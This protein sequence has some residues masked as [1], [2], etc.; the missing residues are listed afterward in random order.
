MQPLWGEILPSDLTAVPPA[1]RLHKSRD[2]CVV[3][4]YVGNLFKWIFGEGVEVVE[5][6]NNEGHGNDDEGDDIR[7]ER[8]ALEPRQ[9]KLLSE[10]RAYAFHHDEYGKA[11]YPRYTT[12]TAGPVKVGDVVELRKDGETKWKNSTKSWYAYVRDTWTT[13]AGLQ[14]TRILWLY[15]PEDMALCM[16][17]RYPYQNE[18]YSPQLRY[19]LISVVF[20]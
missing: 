10:Q 12:G 15:W 7:L 2:R 5:P 6:S 3:T 16:S 18:V 9:V 11:I 4:S 13:S 8:M 20:Q 1:H 17:M 19:N 14:K